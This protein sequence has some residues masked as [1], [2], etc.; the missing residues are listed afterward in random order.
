MIVGHSLGGIVA[1]TAVLIDNHPVTTSAGG[2]DS[3]SGS[4]SSAKRSKSNENSDD[5]FATSKDDQST[6]AGTDIPSV[7]DELVAN[8]SG[9][10]SSSSSLVHHSCAV[11]D[12]ILLSSPNHR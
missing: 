10:A 8:G 3:N 7:Q 9:E 11:S 6:A 4:G 12:I 5:E 1:R 2:S